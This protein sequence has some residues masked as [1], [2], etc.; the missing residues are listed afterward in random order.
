MNYETV[1]LFY[2]H[3]TLRGTYKCAEFIKKG[4]TFEKPGLSFTNHNLGKTCD[5]W[6]T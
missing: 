2:C 4:F 3:T 1:R 6:I 5:K